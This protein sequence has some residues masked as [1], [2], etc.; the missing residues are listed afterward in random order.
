MK[1]EYK[2]LTETIASLHK[3]INRLEAGGKP[4]TGTS[5]TATGSYTLPAGNQVSLN[6]TLKWSGSDVEQALVG[7]PHIAIYV[8]NDNQGPYGYGVGSAV[9]YTK[10]FVFWHLN[11]TQL[12][13][14]LYTTRI[15][16]YVQNQDT[17]DHDYFFYITWNFVT[18]A[19]GSGEG[20]S[21]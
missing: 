20:I 16:I 18:G 1:I 17:I 2:D 13:N 8:D 9:D 4:M 10:H 3:R 6:V 19:S 12:V 7:A 11:N 21:T 14:N 5:P 15:I